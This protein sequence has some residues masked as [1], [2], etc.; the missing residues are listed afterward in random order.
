[1]ICSSNG[2]NSDGSLSKLSLEVEGYNGILET[3]VLCNDG[4]IQAPELRTEEKANGENESEN[5]DNT[6]Q[7]PPQMLSCYHCNSSDNNDCVSDLSG[8]LTTLCSTDGC[9]HE[10]KGEVKSQT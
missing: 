8:D 4:T 10:I 2:C 3:R 5:S 9:Y 1:M 6:N 7:N